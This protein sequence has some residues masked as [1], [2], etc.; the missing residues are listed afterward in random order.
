MADKDDILQ[1]GIVVQQVA[2][3]EW[4]T[5]VYVRKL[6]GRQVEKAMNLIE[7]QE[8]LTQPSATDEQS[9][10]RMSMARM[11]GEL[12][13]LFVCNVAGAPLFSSDDVD[14]ILDECDFAP[15]QRCVEA[16][17]EFNFMTEASYGKLRKNSKAAR[18]A[19][20]G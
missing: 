17:L 9:N 18:R 16:G 7:A 12:F 10:G 1:C 11:A 5:E 2:I 15:V 4:P 8:K 20:P 6:N 3:E 13:V 19:S 14:R